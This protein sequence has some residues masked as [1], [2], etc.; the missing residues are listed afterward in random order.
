[1]VIKQGDIFWKP[2]KRFISIQG[3]WRKTHKTINFGGNWVSSCLSFF[4]SASTVAIHL[5]FHSSH[6]SSSYY[7]Y[8]RNLCISYPDLI[9]ISNFANTTER[10][11]WQWKNAQT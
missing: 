7:N 11:V 8:Y 2:E 6:L 5:Y 3:V 4:L 1:L 9:K 10:G